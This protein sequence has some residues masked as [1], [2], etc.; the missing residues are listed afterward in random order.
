MAS[1]QVDHLSMSS[2]M[3]DRS[4][5]P[6]SEHVA[7]SSFAP[8]ANA[9]REAALKSRRK[10]Q[11]VM[12]EQLTSNQQ[13]TVNASQPLVDEDSNMRDA[14]TTPIIDT[15]VIGTP[16]PQGTFVDTED[17]EIPENSQE[18][19]SS[20]ASTAE[21][22]IREET[23]RLPLF[24]GSESA[25]GSDIAEPSK[26]VRPGLDMTARDLNEAKH[27]ILDLLGLGV[28]PEYLVDCGVSP[29][30]LAVCFYELNLRF[31][32]NLDRRQ[33]NLPPFYDLD[34]HMKDSQRREQ[35]IRQRDR[36]QM[37]P[38]PATATITPIIE[39]SGLLR[40]SRSSPPISPKSGEKSAP[41][42][43][44]PLARLDMNISQN[45]AAETPGSQSTEATRPSSTKE[46][47]IS[48]MEDQKRMELLARKAAMDSIT[49]K[50]AAK[51]AGLTPNSPSQL[52][53]QPHP[54]EIKDVESA[55]DALLASVRMDSESSSQSE[56]RSS[57][58]REDGSASGGEQLPDYDSDA[59]VEDEL[60]T[61]SPSP[62]DVDTINEPMDIPVLAN[63]Q[64]NISPEP[65]LPNTPTLIPS[66]KLS[67]SRVRF[68]ASDSV[69]SSSLPAQPTPVAVPVVARRSRPIASDFIDQL[70]PRPASAS[71]SGPERS[72]LLK[73]KRSFVDPAIWPKRIVIDLDSSDEE[74]DQDEG[75][76]FGATG[77][78][79]SSSKGSVDRAPSR[80]ASHDKP[81]TSGQDQ[82]AQMLLEKELQIKAMM[83]K[84]KMRT[85][86][87][88]K[89]A[90]G[91]RTPV[92]TIGTPSATT[93][94]SKTVIPG[95]EPTSSP[96][97]STVNLTPMVTPNSEAPP[98]I[99]VIE[100]AATPIPVEKE[101]QT[102]P[103]D[104]SGTASLKIDEGKE[105]ALEPEGISQGAFGY[106]VLASWLM[107]V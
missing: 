51:N 73:R 18:N 82:A 7:S 53:T 87:K 62:S 79:S 98:P 8:D 34:R 69:R 54:M 88:K 21:E 5:I 3:Q 96:I 64:R 70:P 36:G 48:L 29:Q 31:P 42:E 13:M 99:S 74:D 90:S 86:Q 60:E 59:M 49:R 50:R 77:S 30:C 12:R 20:G 95:A 4:G 26:Y 104:S 35:I 52:I 83:Q 6:N 10:K 75:A 40:A 44:S 15:P 65:I 33:I 107:S 2:V 85:L 39:D 57:K 16:K 17:G 94:L 106:K 9:L 14:S 68:S 11:V 89:S 67:L 63:S 93:D 78:S 92:P 25:S 66:P 41:I 81:A 19:K 46:L 47:D 23:P 80:T 22:G 1:A 91:S 38:K 56:D 72:G 102:S 32:L 103:K 45:N 84:I 100:Q 101:K 43:S 27:L 71:R 58:E 28:T 97:T 76:P 24:V 105:R 55:V 37:P 61:R